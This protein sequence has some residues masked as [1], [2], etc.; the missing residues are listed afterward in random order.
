MMILS[1]VAIQLLPLRLK[2]P[3]GRPRLCLPMKFWMSCR[4]RQARSQICIASYRKRH[5]LLSLSL[6]CFCRRYIRN[7]HFFST[8][9]WTIVCAFPH[10]IFV[11]FFFSLVS[12]QFLDLKCCGVIRECTTVSASGPCQYRQT[13]LLYQSFRRSVSWFAWTYHSSEYHVSGRLPG[14][15][16]YSLPDSLTSMPWSKHLL[17]SDWGRDSPRQF[18]LHCGP[19]FRQ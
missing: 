19:R 1:Q 2:R 17:I 10:F 14:W 3:V 16:P 4:T 18:I 7:C 15:T 9:T 12:S 8:I 13:L 5:G 6:L 11:V